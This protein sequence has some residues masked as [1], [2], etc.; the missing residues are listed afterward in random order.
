MDKKYTWEFSRDAEYWDNSEGTIEECLA[1]AKEA[2]E[3]TTYFPPEEKPIIEQIDFRVWATKEQFV[4]LR[5][6]LKNNKIKFGRVE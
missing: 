1:D 4:G 6:Y 3:D 2:A 5:D